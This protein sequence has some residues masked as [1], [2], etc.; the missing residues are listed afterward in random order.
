MFPYHYLLT[1]DWSISKELVSD[2]LTTH[3]RMTLPG[4]TLP[5]IFIPAR[6]A[7]PRVLLSIRSPLRQVALE[8]NHLIVQDLIVTNLIL[9]PANEMLEY[10]ERP[11]STHLTYPSLGLAITVGK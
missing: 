8:T 10:V 6:S 9:G 3:L 7:L 2:W 5:H 11:S 1:S 4:P